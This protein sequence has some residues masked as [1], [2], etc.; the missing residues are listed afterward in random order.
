M[1]YLSTLLKWSNIVEVILGLIEAWWMKCWVVE[2]DQLHQQ[3]LWLM[4]NNKQKRNI[5]LVHLF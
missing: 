2:I 1:N 4:L 3:K 5:L